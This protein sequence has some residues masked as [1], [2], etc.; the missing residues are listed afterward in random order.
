VVKDSISLFITLA[1][2]LAF[3]AFGLVVCLRTIVFSFGHV[4]NESSS[5]RSKNNN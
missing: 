2:G 3:V 1:Y 4:I 5:S